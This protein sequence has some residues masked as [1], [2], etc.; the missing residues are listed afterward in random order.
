MTEVITISK[1]NNIQ[2][3]IALILGNGSGDRGYGQP[4]TSS[5]IANASTTIVRAED[6]NKLY[7]DLVK[8]RIHQVGYTA[9]V[10]SNLKIFKVLQNTSS[11][12]L[13]SSPNIII[14]PQTGQASL[15]SDSN[16]EFRGIADYERLIDAIEIDKFVAHSSQMSVQS[17]TQSVRTTPWNKNIYYEFSVNFLSSD[18]RRHFFNAGGKL[19]INSNLLNPGSLKSEDWAA[20]LASTGTIA[21]SHTETVGQ[22]TGSLIGNYDLTSTYVKIFE[23]IGGGTISGVYSGNL[24]TIYAKNISSSAI[25]F[26][27]EFSDVAQDSDIDDLI[28]GRLESSVTC[29]VPD[30]VF[31]DDG[32]SYTSVQLSM[33][34]FSNL[35][36]LDSFAAPI[37]IY[38]LYTNRTSVVN[39]DQFRITISTLNIPDSTPV[40]YT[41]TGVTS[42]DITGAPLTD[43]FIINSNTAFKTFTVTNAI[44]ENK[45]FT[46]K[47]NNLPNKINILFNQTS[48]PLPTSSNRTCIAIIN[49]SSV[50]A[51][52]LASQWRAFRQRWPNR[53][54]YLLQ[55][56]VNSL[57]NLKIPTEFNTDPL[58]EYHRVGTGSILPDISDWYALCNIASL[59]NNSK[60]SIFIDSSRSLPFSAIRASYDYFVSQ[61]NARNISIIQT[62]NKNENWIIPFDRDLN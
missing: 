60:I 50:S 8:A 26:K 7:I 41:I 59:P 53:P 57:T 49:E 56:G 10:S 14:D 16:S 51:S 58:A 19:F 25:S 36:T 6:I 18:H 31:A 28:V 4:V 34:T 13:D 9:Y 38:S 23:R 27:V 17:G 22:Q 21:F 39:N 45:T 46:L 42:A 37:S 52:T 12:G 15:I 33:P 62:S 2:S 55:P 54:F 1:L 5:Q 20:F 61:L 43:A 29:L 3:R 47:L 30:G 24:I 44:T 48:I 35:R 32:V 40:P 11:I